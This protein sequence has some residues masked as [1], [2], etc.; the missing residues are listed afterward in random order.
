[1]KWI[2]VIIIALPIMA[3]ASRTW[4]DP[5]LLNW[6]V[7]S[8]T[9]NTENEIEDAVKNSVTQISDEAEDSDIDVDYSEFIGGTGT[10]WVAPDYT[11]QK[12]A[13]GWNENV[14][15][16]PAGLRSRVDFWKKIYSLYSTNEGVLH[17]SL[18]VDLIYAHL[19]FR[20]IMNN[21]NL[22]ERDKRKQRRALVNEKKKEVQERITRLH[23]GQ[24]NP[25]DPEDAKFV[26]L[27]EGI[28]EDNKYM[29]AL[30]RKRMR[31]QLGQKD[32]F[33]QGIYYSGRYLKSMEKIYQ[34]MGLPKELTRLPFVESSFNVNAR[35][36]VGASGIWQFM[37]YTGRRFMRINYAVDERNDPLRATRAAAK[38]MQLN[39][40]M[41][42]QWSLAITGY[43]HGPAGVQ[44][45]VNKF[46]TDDIVELVDERHGRFGFASANFY[47]CFLAAL[48]V[49]KNAG[50]L[51]GPVIRDF[52]VP[53]AEIVLDR[54]INSKTLVAWFDNNIE[55]AKSYNLH[56]QKPFWSGNTTLAPKD[57]IRV[58]ADKQE[59]VL[60]SLQS[61][62]TTPGPA[63]ITDEDNNY[64]MM[65]VGETLSEISMQFGVSINAIM[66][67]NG[68]DNPR[69][70]RAGQKLI[71]P[72]RRKN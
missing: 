18:H 41:L 25:N 5:Q 27:F 70:I 44:K 13:L 66:E 60:A 67:I 51:F 3:F 58:P 52:Y 10:P 59:V 54:R 50:Q 12:G 69:R 7:E 61:T 9:E 46:N 36:R 31:F 6:L 39:Y 63:S 42:N 56:I 30:K 34:D 35:S 19:D 8:E 15:D 47:A 33:K 71:I 72:T 49:E 28:E 53:T 45:V 57:F 23:K 26:K 22:S 40:N 24:I 62:K 55:K 43:N 29:A 37:R 68:I 17:D 11:G 65:G 64:Y 38:L 2:C 16:V 1:M 4:N 14:F 20:P 21:K 48:E 32:R